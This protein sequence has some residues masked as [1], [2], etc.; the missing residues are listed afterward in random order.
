MGRE[1]PAEET[2]SLF[3]Q[4]QSDEEGRICF[5]TLLLTALPSTSQFFIYLFEEGAYFRA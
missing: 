4:G 2:E 1:T 5:E 3:P